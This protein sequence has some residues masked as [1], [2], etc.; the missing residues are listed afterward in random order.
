[1]TSEILAVELTI[2]AL[3]R[4]AGPP[5]DGESIPMGVEGIATLEFR[6]IVQTRS[7]HF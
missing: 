1:M 6:G 5:L 3:G 4:T 7:E 2:G